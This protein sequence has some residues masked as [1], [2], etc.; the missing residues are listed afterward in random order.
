MTVSQSAHARIALV[1]L[2]VAA[3]GAANWYYAPD[4]AW[5][6]LLAMGLMAVA[7]LVV[8]FVDQVRP[9]AEQ[10]PSE[11]AYLE[12]SVVTA[13][14]LIIASLTYKFAHNFGFEGG[15]LG[16]RVM[17]VGCGVALMVL[18]NYL[19]KALAPVAATRC[20][21]VQAQSI[22]RFAG[23]SFAIAG[24][25]Y[26]G[27]WLFLPVAMAHAVDT[28]IVA[29]ALV[30]TLGRLLLALGGRRLPSSSPTT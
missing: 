12:G 9:L 22:Q 20:L 29:A 18:G 14:L 23:W 16:D 28:P 26:A 3:A 27:A 7:W 2:G 8:V 15:V 4:R 24:L 6:W 21:P 1:S 10:S 13:G 5:A 17:G 25:L 30:L 11:R 19:P